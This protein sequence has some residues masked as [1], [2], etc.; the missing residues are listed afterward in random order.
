MNHSA[1]RVVSHIRVSESAPEPRGRMQL[2]SHWLSGALNSGLYITPHG[3]NS[4]QHSR[5]PDIYY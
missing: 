5:S 4:P 1:V 2:G 3:N